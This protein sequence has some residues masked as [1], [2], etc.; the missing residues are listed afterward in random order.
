MAGMTVY[1]HGIS[2]RDIDAWR[3]A[4]AAIGFTE[5][6]PGAETPRHYRNVEGDRI[7]QYIASWLGEE[8][9]THF[10]TNPATGQQ[11]DLVQI[12]PVSLR[13]RRSDRPLEGDTTVGIPVAG[14]TAAYERMR[15]AAPDL[16]F[17]DPADIDDEDG[18]AF[19]IEGQHMV[20]TR[21]AEPFTLVHYG[22]E[23][24][25]RAR[26][27]YEDVL[28][29]GVE[30]LQGSCGRDRY[31]ILDCGG[32]IEIEVS[33]ETIRVPD[34]DG[35]MYP[36]GNHF[37]LLKPRWDG[38]EGRLESTGLGSWLWAPRGGFAQVFGPSRESIEL[39]DA[40]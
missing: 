37:R 40:D 25:A 7:G 32:R 5:I 39:Y 17:T 24:W 35:K 16:A 36:G 8:I 6:E 23:G 14:P 31:R 30:P 3:A 11:V 33:D 38:I 12:A 21:R 15:A 4:I 28:G 10:I 2:V 27:F 1:H 34:A 29:F 9:H 20:L 13:S 19:A 26:V 18:I 22:P